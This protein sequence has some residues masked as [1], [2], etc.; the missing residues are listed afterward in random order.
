MI[1]THGLTKHY[2]AVKALRNVTLEVRR[3]EVFGL[4]GPNGSGKTTA[5][6]L[7]LGMLKPTAGRA[8]VA[9]FS[10]W[11]HSYEVRRHV[12]FVPGELRL[13]GH[14][15]GLA[16]LKFLS[17]LRDGA[18][19]DRAVAIAE[20]IMTLEL[21][22][23]IRTYSTGMKQKL[24]LAQAFGDPVD[25]LILDEPT[26]ALDPSAREDVLDL[27]RQARSSGQTVVFSGHVLSEVEAVADRVAIMR[28]GRLMHIED[29]HARRTDL[30]LVLI[31]LNG[32]P[33]ES[34]PP[35]LE[36]SIR[37]R[38]GDALLL[39]HR[40]PANP[41]LAWLATQDVADFAI[42]VDDLKSLYDQY[43]G[44]NARQHKEEDDPR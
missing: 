26:S 7:L 34:F 13:Y 27:V 20:T 36:L 16:L 24:A 22:R 44:A 33:P 2:G 18:G 6:R 40:G 43:H 37:E 4:L 15:T 35:E 39:E 25:V 1:S 41:L 19:L 10:C 14:M 11:S 30:R 28:T 31:K 29:M 8:T 32:P 3:G 17:G 5:I 9:G 42:G 21:G 38:R 23:K 12:S